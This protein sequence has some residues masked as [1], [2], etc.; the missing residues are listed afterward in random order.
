VFD[1]KRLTLWLCLLLTSCSSAAVPADKPDA[2]PV[3][4][5]P[6]PVAPA[7]LPL[8]DPPD[9]RAPS[10]RTTTEKPMRYELNPKTFRIQNPDEPNEKVL[11]LTF[12][13]GPAGEATMELLDILDWH[14]VKSIW[15]INGHQVAK[16][17]QDGTY[18]VIPEKAALLREI[19]KRGHLVGN[20]TWWHENLRKLPAEKQREEIVSTSQLI[21]DVL[22]EKPKYFRPPFGAGTPVSETICREQ[23]MVSMNWSV[24]SLDWEP[25]VYKKPNGITRQVISTVHSGGNILFHDRVWTATELDAI[26]T[27]LEK[28]GYQFVLPTEAK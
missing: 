14:K 22:G 5:Q 11:L 9:V 13:D 26:L 28:D 6:D 18:A 23:G 8:P 12:D 25:A 27:Q 2:K 24:G 7:G 15:F 19:H 17:K 21:A 3:I 10:P 4:Q 20:H 16:K 1:V